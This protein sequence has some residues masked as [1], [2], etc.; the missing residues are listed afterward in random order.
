MSRLRKALL[1][2]LWLEDYKK[3]GMK[4]GDHTF[5]EKGVV[6]D[7]SHCWLI[8]IGNNVYLT[9][10]VMLLAHDA[11]TKKIKDFNYTKVGSI[12][13]EDNAFIGVRS[14]ILPGVTI[15]ENSIVAGGSVVTKSVPPNTIVGGNPAK[16]IGTLA[17]YEENRKSHF[18]NTRKIFEEEYTIY[19][20]IDKHKKDQM[21]NELINDIGY[22][23]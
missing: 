14:L 3:M 10:Q 15:G 19:G 2:E 13:I 12:K 7:Y 22:V 23:K 5:I 16:K 9:N 21:F 17:Q 6:I 1:Q 8:E 18:K 20:N 11:S 4:V